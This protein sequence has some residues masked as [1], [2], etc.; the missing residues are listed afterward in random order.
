M[1][2]TYKIYLTKRDADTV[3]TVYDE[4]MRLDP[5]AEFQGAAGSHQALGM[6]QSGS[7]GGDL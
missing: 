1:K 3:K 5:K 2:R 6:H 4:I 7:Y